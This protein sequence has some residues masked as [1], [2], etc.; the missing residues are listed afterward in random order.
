MRA[1]TVNRNNSHQNFPIAIIGTGFAGIGAAI[2]LKKAG[3]HSFTMFE[4]AGEIGGTW[5]D[6]TY[7]G[8]ACDVP[9][10]VYSLSFEPNFDWSRAFATSSEIQS[11]LLG[12]V[13]KW[14]LR[15]HMRLNTEIVE[16]RFDE[17]SGT[18]NLT[19]ND[20]DSFSARVRIEGPSGVSAG[21]SKGWERLSMGLM[22]ITPF[23]RA[24]RCAVERRRSPV[25][26]S[27]TRQLVVPAG[28]NRSGERR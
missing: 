3:I 22:S 12:L 21:W 25:G 15:A 7:P 9:S 17:T 8:A 27:P 10:H 24:I 18:W 14:G 1:S 2:Q 5:R 6:N 20:G 4:R 11:Y 26:V 28:S 19:T 13:E 16:A 23:V